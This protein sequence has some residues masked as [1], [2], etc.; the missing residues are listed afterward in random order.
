MTTTL[1]PELQSA[2]ALY[3]DGTGAPQVTAKGLGDEA[4]EI[5]DLAR[6]HNVPLCENP[7]L[8]ALLAEIELGE[9][10]PEALY[11]AVAHIIAFAWDLRDLTPG[12]TPGPFSGDPLKI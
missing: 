6:Q 10:I 3:Y 7:A 11:I 9:T 2:V 5:I 4:R 12:P 8:V 1:K